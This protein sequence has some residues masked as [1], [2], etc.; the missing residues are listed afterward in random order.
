MHSYS[1]RFVTLQ[2][3]LDYFFRALPPLLFCALRG[4]DLNPV[5]RENAS[6][7]YTQ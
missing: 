2:R 3:S 5:A 6:T 7:A 4:F 1:V